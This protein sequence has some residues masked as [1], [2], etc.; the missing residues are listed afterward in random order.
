VRLLARSLGAWLG[1][2]A[3]YEL[4]HAE[5]IGDLLARKRAALAQHASQMTRLRPGPHWATLDE[6][7]GGD[8]LACFFG[9]HEYFRR[10]AS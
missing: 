6:I 7:A 10:R 8:W 1:L 5:P 3:I 9:D 4:N 2:R